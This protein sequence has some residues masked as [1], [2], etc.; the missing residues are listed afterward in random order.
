PIS[1]SVLARLISAF[2]SSTPN[3]GQSRYARRSTSGPSASA[4]AASPLPR[5]NHPGRFIRVCDQ[6]KTQGIARKSVRSMAGAAPFAGP[7]P[8][9]GTGSPPEAGTGSPPEAGTGA[10]PAG[11][12]P[13]LAGREPMRR[14]PIS[15]SGLIRANQPAKPSASTRRRNAAQAVRSAIRADEA[16]STAEPTCSRCRLAMAGWPYRAKMTSPC[17][18][19]LNEPL[20]EPGAWA[21]TAR[22][23]GPPPRPRA[24]PRPWNRVRDAVGRGP[25]GQPGLGVE[26]AQGGAGRAE[27]LGRVGVPEHGLELPAA[28]RQPLRD[29]G[30]REHAGQHVGRVGQVGRA[31]EQGHHVEHGRAAAGH[32][33][34]GQLVHG[35]DVIGRTGEAH[36]V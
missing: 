9:A 11:R 31:L 16:S 17:S 34:A 35:G 2:S 32:G 5:P 10:E 23:A 19:T 6:A 8:E 27:L 28:G 33:V 24:P 1:R 15:P 18:V 14:P 26:E 22:P 12:R 29:L 36:H 7:P 20:T 25:G 21:S 4:T 30:Q 13:R 3:S